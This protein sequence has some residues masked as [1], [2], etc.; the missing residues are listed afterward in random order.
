MRVLAPVLGFAAAALVG[1]AVDPVALLLLVPAT[2]SLGLGL[3]G[4]RARRGRPSS[5]SRPRTATRRCA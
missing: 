2:G 4:A 3:V 1:F 5:P